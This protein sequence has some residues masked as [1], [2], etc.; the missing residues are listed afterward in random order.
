[1]LH[2]A[3]RKALHFGRTQSMPTAEM[4]WRSFDALMCR[5]HVP[6]CRVISST[7]FHKFF[8]AMIEGVRA[9][10]ADAPLPSFLSL[11]AT[12]QSARVSAAG[13]H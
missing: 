10:I 5:G 7:E 1:M 8:D 3:V 12:L 13:P 9:A 2:F 6:P 11:P 4:L